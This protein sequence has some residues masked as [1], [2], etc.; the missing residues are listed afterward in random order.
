M[1]ETKVKNKRGRKKGTPL[2]EK[3]KLGL[4]KTMT[5]SWDDIRRVRELQKDWS[6]FHK[7]MWRRGE[8]TPT[9]A[10]KAA[11]EEFYRQKAQEEKLNE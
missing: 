1:S 10:D 9:F 2:T 3:N 7:I 8:L 5:A 11:E 4:K 6:E